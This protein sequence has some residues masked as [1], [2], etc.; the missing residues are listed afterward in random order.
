M[1]GT[2]LALGLSQIYYQLRVEP[3]PILFVEKAP[4]DNKSHHLTR[5]L[6]TIRVM[7]QRE[8]NGKPTTSQKTVFLAYKTEVTMSGTTPK[9]LKIQLLE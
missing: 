4:Q 1:Q 9:S 3:D 6:P 5:F 2:S 8:R 7:V